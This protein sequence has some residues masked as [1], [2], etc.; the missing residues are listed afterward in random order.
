MAEWRNAYRAHGGDDLG[1]GHRRSGK[2]HIYIQGKTGFVVQ[3]NRSRL[4]ENVVLPTVSRL[5]IF[6]GRLLRLR[7]AGSRFQ[8]RP[9]Y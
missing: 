7:E 6:D 4:Q 8:H 3:D 5:V 1:V 9:A 2:L